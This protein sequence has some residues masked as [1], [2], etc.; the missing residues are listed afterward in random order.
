[1]NI[2]VVAADRLSDIQRQTTG[3]RRP[4]SCRLYDGRLAK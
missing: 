4:P 2:I 3:H 1:M